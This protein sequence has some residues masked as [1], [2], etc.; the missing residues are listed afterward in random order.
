MIE[1]LNNISFIYISLNLLLFK[2][3]NYYKD[4][5]ILYKRNKI[6]IYLDIYTNILNTGIRVSLY[7]ANLYIYN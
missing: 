5:F 4:I 2:N 7:K 3:I 1:L 6:Y